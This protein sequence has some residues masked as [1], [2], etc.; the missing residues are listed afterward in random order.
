MHDIRYHKRNFFNTAVADI[1]RAL[2]GKSQIGGFILTFCLI[3]YLT[4]LEFGKTNNVKDNYLK[5]IKQRLIPLNYCYTG[6]EEELFSVRCALVHTYG[7]SKKIAN[8]TYGGYKLSFNNCGMHMQKVNDNVLQLCLY[9]ILTEIVFA[10]HLFFEE[11]DSTQL[12]QVQERLNSQILIIDSEPPPLYA[13]MHTALSILDYDRV[14]LNDI[15]GDYTA[16][17]LYPDL[18]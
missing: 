14:T 16:K 13:Q 11:L 17:I 8:K 4:W 15:Q 9:T 5:W 7:P 6:Q 18:G 12:I 10:A 2:D 1:Y 3:D